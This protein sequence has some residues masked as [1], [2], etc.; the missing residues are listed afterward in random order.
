ML[1]YAFRQFLRDPGVNL[2]LVLTLALG[3]GVNTGIFSILN[4]IWR[5][6][7]VRSPDQIVVLAAD[8]KGD[9]TGLRYRHSYQVLEDLRRQATNEFSDLFAFELWVGG[10]STG[11]KTSE[12]LFSAVTGN[13][14]T[15]LGVAPALGRVFQPG[16][17]E[18]AAAELNLVL[19]Y[20]FWQK[21]FGGDPTVIGRQVRLGGRAATVIGVAPKDF[22]GTYT[23][24]DMEGYIPLSGVIS[25]D[26]PTS[27]QLF[28]DRTLRWMTLLGRL[29]PGVS[30]KEAS[31][32]MDVLARRMEAEYPAT[33]KGIG[34]RVVPEPLARPIPLR[35]VA[36]LGPLIQFTLLF[37]AGL[38][39]LVAC[40]NVANILLVRST[41]RERELAIR[42]ALGSGSGRLIR[43]MLTESVLLA[44]LGA[45][46]GIGLGKWASSAFAGSIDM[47][48]DLPF[49]VDF[50]FDWR[51]FAYAL[52]GALLTGVL[53]GVWPALRASRTDAAGA[54]HDGG[55]AN[56][57]GPARQRMRGLLVVGQVAGSLVLLIC[58]GL[59]VRSLRNA[60]QTD[61]GFTPDH[62][63]NARMNPRWA[64]YDEQRTKDFYR[65]LER[66]V[67]AWPEAQSVSLA[68]SS[69]LGYLGS[70]RTIYIEGRAVVPDEQAAVT[71]FNPVDEDYFETMQIR[72]VRGRPF[73][74]SDTET[75]LRVAIVNQT[76]A[77]RYWPGEDPLG[78]RFRMETP[79]S[80][81]WEVVGVARDSKYLAVFEGSLPY[82]YVP[83]E[84]N[85]TPMRVLQIRTSVAPETLRARLEREISALDPEVPVSDLQT[86]TRAL[87]SAQGFL[88][89]RIGAAQALAM[90]IL[91]LVLAMVGVYGV[92]SY[93]AAQR[94]RE[95]G[96]RMALGATPQTVLGVVLRQG[97]WLVLGGVG[98]G[99]LGALALT[100]VLKRFLL[101]VSATDPLTFL[102]IPVL[103]T[104]VALWACYIP[105]RR[106]ARL[107][108][109][110][111]LRHE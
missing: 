9:D 45:V 5:P 62:L 34:I 109:M 30:V 55:R 29:K 27:H 103:L 85:Y 60:Q 61:L 4:G 78:K 99:L 102:A 46:A 48:T 25:D 96:I 105:A 38:V 65:E 108:P 49:M 50:S 57:G 91:G 47:A 69:P 97:V 20:S 104:L 19:G 93:G 83:L 44:L 71:G 58:A 77:S 110:A 66:R 12:V 89:F 56:S 70:G 88:L 35:F 52:T 101:L 98:V 73:R 21:R 15:A 37:L 8:T 67:R 64:G 13:Y 22:Y 100:R 14:F 40:M 6:L 87:G 106:A 72:I 92:V 41:V 26:N 24:A 1:R 31:T 42:S 11:G 43:Q 23:G 107:D 36:D 54:L 16:E 90:G 76:M 39:L 51:V 86:M 63:L 79:D 33:D 59:F 75:A 7:P 17:G 94:T 10:F 32:A 80:P 68:Y 84:Q 81:L 53:T 3:I 2:L 18:N 28:T 111:A 74:E 95:I 82:F